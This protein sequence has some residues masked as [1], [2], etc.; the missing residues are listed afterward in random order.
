[1]RGRRHT[2]QRLQ[3]CRFACPVPAEQRDDFV[4]MQCE[5]DAIE[6][7]ALA[8]ERIDSVH[9]QK[10]AGLRQCLARTSSD[11]RRTRTDVNVL[12]FFACARIVNSPV[13][14]NSAFVHNRDVIGQLKN[15]VNIV[16]DQQHRQVRRYALDDCADTFTL[17]SRKPRERFIE[18]K[19]AWCSGER[20]PHVEKPLASV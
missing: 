15:A 12:N 3:Q 9:R 19:Y 13:Q 16:F 4:V 5:I 11:G 20:D 6:N 2:D 7:M 8:V 17:S 1:M 10:D 14:E 18:Q